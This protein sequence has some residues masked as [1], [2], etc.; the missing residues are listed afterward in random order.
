MIKTY[1]DWLNGSS[2]FESALL[3][4]EIELKT[5]TPWTKNKFRLKGNIEI[6]DAICNDKFYVKD[7]CTL[8]DGT[9]KDKSL[10]TKFQSEV[11]SITPI[12]IPK[13]S[14]I[15]DVKNYNFSNHKYKFI[16]EFVLELYGK[17]IYDEPKEDDV[18]Y[19]LK[20]KRK[21]PLRIMV[22]KMD[23]VFLFYRIEDGSTDSIN[24]G[25]TGYLKKNNSDDIEKCD[26]RQAIK[27]N[28][29]S[30]IF[31]FDTEI[32][33]KGVEDFIRKAKS[34][35]ISESIVIEVAC[36]VMKMK[37]NSPTTIDQEDRDMI[38]KKFGF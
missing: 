6:I 8:K 4:L 22:M 11:V 26:I 34:K 3:E 30:E 17:T 25:G 23:S 7:L 16:Q 15:K 20:S 27:E 2:N 24:I 21:S 5:L 31:C 19:V 13:N 18:P 10:N 12:A 33:L 36:A 38:R 37:T 29:P 9:F 28:N 14:D 35:E 1:T 32:Y